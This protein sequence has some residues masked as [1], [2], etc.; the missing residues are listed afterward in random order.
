[1]SK[2]LKLAGAAPQDGG[3]AVIPVSVEFRLSPSASPEPPSSQEPDTHAQKEAVERQMAEL[4]SQTQERCA[5]MLEEATAASRQMVEEAQ[6]TAIQIHTSAKEAGFEQGYEAGRQEA[7]SD[8]E[9]T[10]TD[11]TVRAQGVL[12]QAQQERRDLL[13]GMGATVSEIAMEAVRVL[14]GRELDSSPADIESLVAELLQY[15]MESTRVEVRVHPDDFARAAQ[16]HP[17]WKA[18]KFADWEV[19]IVPDE[20]IC[21]GGCEIRSEYGRVDASMETKLELLQQAVTQTLE[22]RVREIVTA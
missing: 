3:T 10:C 13:L 7:L 1:M 9:A 19:A 5:R 21:S 11:L 22:Q 18:A 20:S 8:C 2:I 16:A 15:V 14:L 12:E 6:Q 17:V 4:V